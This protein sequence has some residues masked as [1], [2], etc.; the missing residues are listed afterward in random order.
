M[1]QLDANTLL[2]IINMKLRNNYKSLE[3]LG[4]DLNIDIELLKEKLLTNGYIYEESYNQFIS[5]DAAK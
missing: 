3:D 1:L 4:D 2:S 5:I